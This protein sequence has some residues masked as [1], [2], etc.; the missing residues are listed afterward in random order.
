LPCGSGPRCST[1]TPSSPTT[2]RPSTATTPPAP[3]RWPGADEARGKGDPTPDDAAKARR[4]A[5]ALRWLKA[6][7]ATWT[8]LLE[9]AKPEER[10]TFVQALQHW[11][12]DAD[13]A[14]VRNAKAIEALPEPEREGWRTLWKDV[15]AVLGP[16][17]KH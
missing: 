17:E 10:A 7:L 11:Q 12:Q 16:S 8:K 13:L 2:D 9:T 1:P 6:E 5:Q 14:G 3:P 15:A 4:R